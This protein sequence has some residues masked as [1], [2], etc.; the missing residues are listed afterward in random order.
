MVDEIVHNK[1]LRISIDDYLKYKNSN[2]RLRPHPL[3]DTEWYV[4]R[5]LNGDFGQNAFEHYIANEHTGEFDPNPYFRT[6]FYKS[7]QP[8]GSSELFNLQH[9]ID[10]GDKEGVQPNVL[11]SPDFYRR[12]SED[13]A[14]YENSTLQHYI[15]YG[16]HEERQP[17]LL[18]SKNWY[19]RNYAD[20]KISGIEPLHHFIHFGLQEGR[21]P[22]PLLN[23][24]FMASQ[25]DIDASRY[26]EIIDRLARTTDFNH[27]DTHLSF[28][29]NYYA[30]QT[31]GFDHS[32][33]PL[34]H[35]L[36]S[37]FRTGCPNEVFSSSWYLAV[38]KDVDDELINPLEHY[39]AYGWREGRDP[40][41]AF[42]TDWYLANNLDIDPEAIDPLS[43]FV[44]YGNRE[45]RRTKPP[46]R[47]IINSNS[48]DFKAL[49]DR[50]SDIRLSCFLRSNSRISFDRVMSP[51]LTIILVLYN[52]AHLS[53]DC[54]Q[55]LRNNIDSS[56]VEYE[57]IVFDNGSSDRTTDLLEAIDNAVVI[58]NKENIGYLRAVNKCVE[59]AR[60]DFILL[61]NNDTYVP[62]GTIE[63][64]IETLK[65]DSSIG[66]VGAKLILPNGVLQEAG[67]I[68]WADGSCHGYLRNFDPAHFAANFT[69]DV[70]YCS[71]AF[72]MT[73]RELY[74]RLG[75]FDEI[76]APAYYEETD[77]CA[78]YQENGYRIV[79][80]PMVEIIHY[81]F[82]SASS[83]TQ[84]MQLQKIN[85]A[86]FYDRHCRLL[87]DKMVADQSNILEAR[88]VD[89][90]K[91]K[92]LFIDDKVPYSSLGSG[93]PRA[94][95]LLNMLAQMGIML[96]LLPT[97]DS[98][99]DW[100]EVRS[101]LDKRIEV[102][103]GYPRGNMN[104]FLTER[105]GYYDIIAV[106]RP[107]NMAA[108]LDTAYMKNPDLN[109]PF[110]WYDAEA[111]F[112]FREIARK[113]IL[114]GTV[115]EK[116]NALMVQSELDLSSK[117]QIISCVSDQEA[118]LFKQH[119]KRA[120]RLG[121]LV[122]K[123]FGPANFYA[124]SDFLFVG[125]L[126]D[127]LTPNT[128]SIIWFIDHVWPFVTKE[129]SSARLILV[130]SNK[131]R[132]VS[133]RLSDKIVSLGRQED[134]EAVYNNSR[135]FV[136]PTRFSAGIPHKVHEAAAAGLPCVVT[137]QLAEQLSWSH[138]NQ[139]MIADDPM[140]FARYCV[141]LYSDEDLWN[142]IRINAASAIA[143]D[144]SEAHY[145]EAI[146]EILRA[147]G[148][149]R[150]TTANQS[151]TGTNLAEAGNPS[152]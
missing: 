11:F 127:E 35:Y 49:M 113:K 60:S 108:L 62:H 74:V 24:P 132:E 123:S 42:D 129:V 72:L 117:A 20:V 98:Q 7:Q 87:S 75:G 77:L 48:E 120:V 5:Y 102:A 88:T 47:E 111:L 119:G 22:H 122:A 73:S 134:I 78:K 19:E 112:S 144:C 33:H 131:S 63:R 110:I 81:E 38:Y 100:A 64:A 41:E 97:D 128:D 59:I 25:L 1:I 118:A 93:F 67:S 86:K 92:V 133:N 44:R 121:H 95:A 141:E 76:Y 43:H 71:G 69:R 45:K 101:C 15:E 52:K 146:K 80:E 135:V 107:H 9:Y 18:F 138:R 96:T 32:S 99:H 103:F 147:S 39:I 23:L 54:L 151:I 14:Q 109:R 31:L 2:F 89:R 83:A 106:S 37:A 13:L 6:K 148:A 70:D 65:E 79:Y 82:G 10:R 143:E 3:F 21:S 91:I 50:Q 104:A 57:I 145:V 28:F 149:L 17:H 66:A 27:V 116:A 150:A 136:A 142:S 46:Y 152:S 12:A 51:V 84:A 139:L 85:K 130:G 61:L 58:T 56:I 137:K 34:V 115:D 30:Q 40:S 114:A 36:R 16:R 26:E 29:S 124:R 4:H 53:F 140:S 90:Q 94:G 55:S 126:A 105:T 68:I 8:W 125:G